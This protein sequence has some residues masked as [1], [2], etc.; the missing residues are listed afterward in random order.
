MK[1]LPLLCCVV[2]AAAHAQTP[3]A[4][5]SPAGNE[6]Q[7]SVPDPTA[8]FFLLGVGYTKRSSV[9]KGESGNNLE[10]GFPFIHYRSKT[11]DVTTTNASYHFLHDGDWRWS[12]HVG[13]INVE[14]HDNATATVLDGTS[15]REPGWWAGP[16]V[17]YK[18]DWGQVTATIETDAAHNGNGYQVRMGYAKPFRI[19]YL[20][21]TPSVHVRWLSN[22]YVN[23]YYGVRADEA[24][25]SRPV[26]T[27]GAAT[28]SWVGLNA[29]MPVSR[30]DGFMVDYQMH[31]LGQ[32]MADSPLV[33]KQRYERISVVYMHRF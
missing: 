15:K 12:V 1:F 27:P 10:R 16:S 21:L 6:P 31:Q 2:A 5:S 24:S 3:S 26:Y 11:L 7:T 33:D 30:N 20:Q 17:R 4:P 22:D 9:F 28:A 18:N 13:W 23:Y 19:G 25:A 29:I 32:S 14:A 8:E